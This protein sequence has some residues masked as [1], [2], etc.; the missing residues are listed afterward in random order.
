[1]TWRDGARG[2]NV[3]RGEDCYIVW[4]WQFVV[5]MGT[6]PRRSPCQ[7]PIELE[8]NDQHSVVHFQCNS[9][10]GA[11]LRGVVRDPLINSPKLFVQPSMNYLLRSSLYSSFTFLIGNPKEM[12]EFSIY[13]AQFQ[14]TKKDPYS[15]FINLKKILIILIGSSFGWKRGNYQDGQALIGKSLVCR[16]PFLFRAPPS[17][18]QHRDDLKTSFRLPTCWKW[19]R[20]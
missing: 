8:S 15:F 19:W 1:M 13:T 12:T 18:L 10:A 4:Q 9:T 14:S 2:R 3:S 17:K 11:T 16:V 20:R 5:D 6:S 7:E